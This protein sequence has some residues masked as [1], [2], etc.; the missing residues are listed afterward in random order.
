MKNPGPGVGANFFSAR[1]LPS[2]RQDTETF[3]WRH[4]WLAIF[5]YCQCNHQKVHDPQ[6]GPVSLSPPPPLLSSGLHAF[7]RLLFFLLPPQHHLQRL[8]EKIHEGPGGR[9]RTLSSSDNSST[10]PFASLSASAL[11]SRDAQRTS[12]R[13]CVCLSCS[14]HSMSNVDS[15]F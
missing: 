1:H 3:A 2:V 13:T 15:V 11:A 12:G 6:H 10:M 8:A 9:I 14:L 4:D 7:V 5:W